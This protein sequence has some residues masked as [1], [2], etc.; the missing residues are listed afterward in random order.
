VSLRLEPVSLGM[1]GALAVLH[2]ACFPEDP[3][4]C[5]AIT[6]IVGMT[7]FFGRFAW[8]DSEPAGFALALDLRGECEVV[9]LAVLAERRRSGVA[10]SLLCALC[11]EA[12]LRGALYIFLE[13]AADNFAAHTLYAARGFVAVG[14]R[15]NYYR[16][17]ERLVDA[18][19]LRRALADPLV[20]C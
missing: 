12:R 4:D 8:Q 10:S 18:L 3:W 9:S 6:Q 19:V 5:R 7:G 1:A 16:R 14:R 11:R 15:G 17:G 13:V 2:G 20:C